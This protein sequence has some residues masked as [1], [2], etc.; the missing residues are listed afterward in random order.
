MVAPIAHQGQR[1]LHLHIVLRDLVKDHLVEEDRRGFK[2]SKEYG[3]SR[4]VKDDEIKSPL[5]PMYFERTLD[6][7]EFRI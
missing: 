2:F 4:F 7:D 1:D 3:L 6:R 5:H